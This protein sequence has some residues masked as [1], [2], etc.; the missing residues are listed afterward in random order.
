M[1]DALAAGAAVALLAETASAPEEDVVGACVG[2]LGADLA[3]RLRVYSAGLHRAPEEGDEGEGGD[4]EGAGAFR[5]AAARLQQGAAE[6]FVQQLSRD[7]PASAAR[8]ALGA[9]LLNPGGA[10]AGARR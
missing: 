6:A 9:S 8:V 4:G 10:A 7:A 3:P 2:Q 5:A 1:R